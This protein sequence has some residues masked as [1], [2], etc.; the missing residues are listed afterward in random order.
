MIE[1]CARTTVCGNTCCTCRMIELIQ[2]NN[3]T[4][5]GD[6]ACTY[7]TFGFIIKMQDLG[8]SGA[9][10]FIN[11]TY[12]PRPNNKHF[13]TVLFSGT[14][15]LWFSLR[16]QESQNIEYLIYWCCWIMCYNES[17]LDQMNCD[18]VSGLPNVPDSNPTVLQ[19]RV[20]TNQDYCYHT[21]HQFLGL[22]YARVT[23][24][25]L[26]RIRNLCHKYLLWI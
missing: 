20:R 18:R 7:G 23:I 10:R 26:S 8:V 1:V 14:S 2:L 13:A 21:H 22:C 25:S 17:F 15:R 16:N 11:F 3:E 5:H 4:K 6:R 12:E 19:A 9:C 24:L